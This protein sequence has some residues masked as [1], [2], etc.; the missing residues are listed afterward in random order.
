MPSVIIRHAMIIVS[1]M[2]R[3]LDFYVDKL[4]FKLMRPPRE[5][6]DPRDLKKN[7]LIA[8]ITDDA[9]NSME[10]GYRKDKEYVKGDSLEHISIEVEDVE[11]TVQ[12]LK[13]K[14]VAIGNEFTVPAIPG[15]KFYFLKG[16][17]DV[18]IEYV[19]TVPEQASQPR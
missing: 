15:R 6:P 11:K 12:D 18:W 9:G 8:F 19:A 10:L 1:N 16:F 13:S 2:E 14:G 3:A 4:G 7:I 5:M 17:D